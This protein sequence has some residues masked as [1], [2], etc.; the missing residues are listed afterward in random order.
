[1]KIL[2]VL[3]AGLGGHGNVFFSMVKADEKK[4]YQFEALFYGIEEVKDDYIQQ[5][6][7]SGIAWNFVK[8]KVGNHISFL[9]KMAKAIKKAKPDIIFL[10]ASSNIPAA[11]MATLGVRH[12]PKIIVRETQANHLKTKNDKTA[13][14]L[15][16]RFA[17]KIVF[18]S[19]QYEETVKHE[20]GKKY[21]SEKTIVIPNGLDVDLYKPAA[22]E[23]K[24]AAFTIG[25][26]SRLV[27][28]KD[29]ATLIEAF[30]KLVKEKPE[31]F[32]LKIAGDGESRAAL[33]KL[34]LQLNLQQQIEFTGML[35]EKELV[36]F[37]QGLDL[38]V[39]ASLG[40]TMSTA[41]MQAM[42]CG[43]PIIASDVPGIN[44]MVTHKQTG[45]LVPA[46]DKEKM[47][48][49]LLLLY[50]DISLRRQLAKN[51]YTYALKEFDSKQMFQKYKATF[52]IAK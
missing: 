10:H 39:H 5:C 52:S 1:M 26:Q 23:I 29:H 6:S 43:L 25:M 38:Y 49:A 40:E 13:L 24:N 28:L 27:A 46:K 45:L 18:L 35:T 9:W 32:K 14:K 33:E 11:Y 4:D 48:S 44:N 37:L 22:A 7:Q 34:V 20:L 47:A 51:T 19:N 36:D 2:H 50:D 30:A 3:Y 41:I 8:K 17:D 15:A 16:M 21:R 42:A 12:K 31:P